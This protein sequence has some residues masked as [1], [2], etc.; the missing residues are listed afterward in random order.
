MATEKFFQVDPY[1]EE[2]LLLIEQFEKENEIMIKTSDYLKKLRSLKS[3]E[4]YIE[5]KKNKNE[6]NENLFLEDNSKIKDLCYIK[7]EKDRKTCT[8]SFSPIKN[9]IKNRTLISLATDYALNMLNMEEVFILAD[10][11]DKNMID[12]LENKGF[13]NLGE[14][15]KSLVFLKEKENKKEMQRKI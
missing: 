10:L 13:E 4:E 12:N 9:R 3:Q 1:N 8:I 7:A 5:E 11:E 6:I 2:H 15:N 14:E